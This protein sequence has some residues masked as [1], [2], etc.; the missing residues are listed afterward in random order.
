MPTSPDPYTAGAEAMREAA[1][2]VAE[3]R[4][5]HWRAKMDEGP[6]NLAVHFQQ[7]ADMA[8]LIAV[9]IRAL[10]LPVPADKGESDAA[11]KPEGGGR[12]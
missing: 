3:G 9:M 12:G 1:A 10:P 6:F 8:G 5:A 2:K 11:P 4:E 7:R